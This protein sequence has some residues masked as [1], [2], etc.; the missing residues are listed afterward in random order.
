VADLV[1][2]DTASQIHDIGYKRYSGSRLGRFYAMRSLYSHGVRTAFGLGR[3]AKAKIFPWIVVGI[4]GV[5]A[6]VMAA[7]L[8]Q[9]GTMIMAYQ[10]FPIS[11]SILLVIFLAVTGPEMVSR[12]LRNKTLPLY[13]SRP[14]RRTDYALAKLGALVTAAFLLLAGPLTLVGLVGMFSGDGFT[15]VLREFR[16]LLGGYAMIAVS[17]LIYSCLALLISSFASKRAFAAAGVA[18]YF[19]VTS[20]V[21]GAIYGLATGGLR[22]VGAMVNLNLLTQGVREFLFNRSLVDLDQ[23]YINVFPVV[24]LAFVAL[25]VGL[26]LLRYRKVSL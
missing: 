15:D 14:L 6:V 10:E 26:V 12:D 25:C 2:G 8:A 3:S 20:A 13:F 7:V 9:T 21:G 24:A 23:S 18:A 22:A 1:A 11:L 16:A 4:V 17:A 5:V 19:L